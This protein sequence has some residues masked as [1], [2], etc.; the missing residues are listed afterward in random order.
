MGGKGKEPDCMVLMR[1][2]D[3]AAR[4]HQC[5]R[6][7]DV[8]QTPYINHPIAV[9]N[10][11]SSTGV[12][13]VRILQA[14]ILHDTV[15]DTCTTVEEL[16][17]MFG[18][19][20]AR[21]VEE[22]TDDTSL[23]GME[24]KLEQLRSAPF[25]SKEAQMVKLADKLHNLESIRRS[26]PVGWGPKRIQNYFLWAKQ[27]TDICASA[28]PPLAARL[29]HLYETAY[30]R[31]NGVYIPCHPEVCGTLTEDE[32]SRIDSRLTGLK[33]GESPRPQ[34]LFT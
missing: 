25:R 9:A 6:R 19:Q 26:P 27:V 2:I 7:K 23:S 20:V 4:K 29:K 22:C 10:L 3:F 14:A 8:D 12:T 1:T 33:V 11:L 21:I 32:K 17:N 28:H 18:L 5:Q 34:P 30:T 24:R 15:E 16:A 13:D 31:V